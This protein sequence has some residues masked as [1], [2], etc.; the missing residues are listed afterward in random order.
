[1]AVDWKDL[2]GFDASELVERLERARGW[3]AGGEPFF[4]GDPYFEDVVGA[5]EAALEL[6]AEVPESDARR[7]V[8][9]ALFSAAR[10][11][12][13]APL[14]AEVLRRGVEERVG[15]FLEAPATPYVLLGSVSAGHFD[16]LGPREIS[17]CRLSFHRGVPQRF[18]S[19]YGAA[20]ARARARVPALRRQEDFFATRYA[21]AAVEAEG[22]S[23]TEAASRAGDALAAQ[24][25]LWNLALRS[26]RAVVPTGSWPLNH[27]L[28]GPVRSLH[29]PNGDHLPWYLWYEPGYVGPAPAPQSGRLRQHREEVAEYERLAREGLA[30]S[31]YRADVTRF[32]RDYALALDGR[33]PGSA[34]VKLWGLLER[35]TGVGTRTAHTA[36]VDRTTFLIT[37]EEQRG[38]HRHFLDTL[39]RHR[40]SGVHMGAL[41][42]DART[43][44]L[45][46]RRYAVP[47][48]ETHLGDYFR[49][50]G[51]AQAATFM[52][53]SVEPD[54]LAQ[55]LRD[56]RRQG[57]TDDARLAELAME[58]HGHKP[59]R[60]PHR[61]PA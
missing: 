31:R 47:V 32:L 34:F 24:R 11:G 7:I 40:H 52:D 42:D 60:E 57:R 37:D 46:L 17:G 6:P 19:G 39:R 49:F 1:M 45:Q 21:F 10:R 35:M 61:D 51:M 18:R 58:Y 26:A 20:W 15:S 22:R 27:V 36:V 43:L 25:G 12:P 55:R 59:D 41:P 8:G 4:S 38:L 48:L 44:L 9:A 3:H 28:P 33:D 14:T 29:C 54:R 23:E 30:R 56:L 53:Q 16:G 2:Q 13:C 50:S 5:L